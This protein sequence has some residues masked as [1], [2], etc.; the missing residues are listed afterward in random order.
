MREFETKVQELKH[1]VLREVSSLAFDGDLTQGILGIPERIIPG[2]QPSTRCCIYKERAIIGDRV[3][4]ALGGDMSNPGVVEVISTACDECPVTAMEVGPSCRGC[5]ANRCTHV[6]PV[7]AISIVNHKATIDHKKCIVCGKCMSACP[8]SAIVKNQRPCERSCPAGAISMRES[9]HKASIDPSKCISCGTCTYACPF[10]AI[11]DKSW[12]VQAIN[13][14][15]GSTQWGYHVHAVVAPAIAGQFAG[16]TLGQVVTGLKQLGFYDVHEV[17]EGGDLTAHA[18]AQELAEKGSLY[19]SC[20]PAFVSYVKIHHPKQADKI[21]HTPSPMVMMGQK[22]KGEDPDARVVFIGPCVAKKHEFR[23]GKTRGVVDCVLTF[24][25]LDAMF[26]GQHIEL[27]E[28]EETELDVASSFGR[29]FAASGGVS[30]AVA[31]SL[32]EQGID[33]E[34]KSVPCGGIAACKPAIMKDAVGK[35][36]GN[37]I[38]GMACE[39]GCISGAGCRIRSPKNK[40]NLTQ[41]AKA[42]SHTT[43]K[44]VAAPEEE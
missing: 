42:A 21:S 16:A 28:L 32:K 18:E 3:K 25:E 5:L 12:I 39:L 6:C 44:S 34:V 13:L 27:G 38:E 15:K 24:E 4:L 29:A 14:L 10:G 8:Y 11:M 19:S 30:A 17:A 35:L 31:Q 40:A 22:I 37:F 33:F 43:I 26:D 20:C 2:P 36:E 7:G 41:Y 23:L 9:D 1:S